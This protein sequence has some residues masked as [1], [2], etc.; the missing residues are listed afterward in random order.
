M[1]W[2]QALTQISTGILWELNS[3]DPML[4]PQPIEFGPAPSTSF[5]SSLSPLTELE[6]EN[7]SSP[8]FSSSQSD[9]TVIET[10]FDFSRKENMTPPYPRDPYFDRF[11]LTQQE[12]EYASHAV[13]TSSI[14]DFSTKV[15]TVLVLLFNF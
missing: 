7:D 4:G 11:P 9:L 1:A 3:L 14:S 12:R 2:E 10:N 6:S 13:P 15:R 8:S 5:N